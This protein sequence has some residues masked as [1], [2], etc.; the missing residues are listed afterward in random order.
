MSISAAK[1]SLINTRNLLIASLEREAANP[2]ANYSAD[3]ESVDFDTF[4]TNQMKRINDLKY[5]IDEEDDDDI[6]QFETRGFS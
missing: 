5:Q 4:Y 6:V 2:K 1:Q 3:G